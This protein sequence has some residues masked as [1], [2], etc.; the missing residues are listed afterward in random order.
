M[1]LI[2]K[3]LAAG[4][5]ANSVAINVGNSSTVNL[6]NIVNKATTW[7]GSIAGVV[8]FFY[9]VYSGFVYLTAGGSPDAAKKGSQGIMNAIIGLVIIALAWGIT[10]AIT[11]T[12]G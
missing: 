6:T 8:A 5:D 11:K 4:V 2:E 7:V 12:L 3:V 9:L 10:Q 1:G